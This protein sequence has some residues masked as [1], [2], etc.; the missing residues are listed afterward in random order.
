MAS[1]QVYDTDEV[2]LFDNKTDG[3]I[4]NCTKLAVADIRDGNSDECEFINCRESM[5]LYGEWAKEI[6]FD[7][8]PL[9]DREVARDAVAFVQYA[10][11]IAS[12]LEKGKQVVVFC[13]NGR[14]R[15]PCVVAAFFIIYRGHSLREIKMWFKE[16]YPKQRPITAKKSAN[17]PNIEK[18]E[19]VLRLLGS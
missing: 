5:S 10:S 17:F 2:R 11:S 1:Y 16:V 3:I 7:D 9:G 19:A 14:S 4:I 18:F 6:K 12:A 13:T 15:S 8:M